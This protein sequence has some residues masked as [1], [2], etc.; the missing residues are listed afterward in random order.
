[1]VVHDTKTLFKAA[2]HINVVHGCYYLNKHYNLV[3]H[4][5]ALLMTH[6]V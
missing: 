2:S 5:I 3:P 6:L 4:N 1:M